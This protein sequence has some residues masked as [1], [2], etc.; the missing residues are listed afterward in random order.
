MKRI[1][2]MIFS[3]IFTGGCVLTVGGAGVSREYLLLDNFESESALTGTA[4]EGFTDQVMGGVSELSVNRVSSGDGAYLRMRGRVST[5]NNGGFIQVRLKFNSDGRFFD[6]TG[7]RG[8][9]L[10][11]RGEDEG[12]YIFLRT[13][14]TLLPWKFYKA[15]FAVTSEW[16]VVEIPWEAFGPGDYGRLRALNVARLKSLALVAYGRDFQANLDVREAGLY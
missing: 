14:A 12:Y 8:I 10:E 16:S 1:I 13:S 7:Y 3:L 15:S 4:W 2:F 5:D 6:A 9:R 11:V